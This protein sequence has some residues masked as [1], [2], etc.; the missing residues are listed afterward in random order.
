M[1]NN[2]PKKSQPNLISQTTNIN[3]INNRIPNN[4]AIQ[5]QSVQKSPIK[6][7][8]LKTNLLLIKFKIDKYKTKKQL[9][10]EKL[11]KELEQLILS[12]NVSSSFTQIR[13]ILQNEDI[14]D[15]CN[16]LFEIISSLIQKSALLASTQV[17]SEIKYYVD[18]LIYASHKLVDIEEFL[19]LKQMFV[20]QFGECY[21]NNIIFNKQTPQINQDLL[22]HL[23]SEPKSSTT[24]INKLKDFCNKK[25]IPFTE[26]FISYKI[27]IDKMNEQSKLNTQNVQNNSKPLKEQQKQNKQTTTSSL[28]LKQEPKSSNPSNINYTQINNKKLNNDNHQVQRKNNIQRSNESTLKRFEEFDPFF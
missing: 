14:I 1:N 16:L 5:N 6:L 19:T 25:Q 18:S 11:F 28:I 20:N 17:P 26:E 13:T 23:S 2:I 7:A 9:I 3:Q 4:Q 12:K 15:S 8:E 27:Q 21:V 24:L 10:I 22:I